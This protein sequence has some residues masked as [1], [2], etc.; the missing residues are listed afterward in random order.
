MVDSP[1]VVK[2]VLNGVGVD[3]R[4]SKIS[5]RQEK[6]ENLTTVVREGRSEL[7]LEGGDAGASSQKLQCDSGVTSSRGPSLV[8]SS[9]GP[10]LQRKSSKSI[11]LREVS[12]LQEGGGAE[13]GSPQ[14]AVQT[15]SSETPRQAGGSENESWLHLVETPPHFDMEP[16][17]QD[18]LEGEE[19]VFVCKGNHGNDL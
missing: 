7:H 10:S 17:N 3:Q 14:Q 1:P 5:E 16:Q 9:R 19:V 18:V 6:M 12:V 4:T 8:A 2:H 11:T 15:M 13:A